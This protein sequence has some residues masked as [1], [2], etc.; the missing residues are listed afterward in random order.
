M[1][2]RLAIAATII[3]LSLF[4]S[5]GFA[6]QADTLFANELKPIGRAITNNR[7]NLE[8]ITSAAHF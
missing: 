3:I 7:H 6:E 2:N 4:K 1:R 5:K 8:L